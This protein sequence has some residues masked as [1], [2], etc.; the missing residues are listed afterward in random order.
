[1]FGRSYYCG[2]ISEKNAGETVVLKGWVQKRSRRSHFIDLWTGLNRASGFQ[3]G[4]IR[5]ALKRDTIRSEY[6]LM[7]GKS[8]CGQRDRKSK[9]KT[10]YRSWCET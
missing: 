9:L 2:E 5:K 8:F 7:T 6:V 10:G 1:M 4:S 3:S